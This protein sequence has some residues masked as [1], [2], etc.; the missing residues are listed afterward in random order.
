V[1]AELTLTKDE[2]Q[3]L[4]DSITGEDYLDFHVL[5][6]IAKSMFEPV[7]LRSKKGEKERW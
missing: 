1:E 3:E 7:N 6:A 4:H 2:R 5:V